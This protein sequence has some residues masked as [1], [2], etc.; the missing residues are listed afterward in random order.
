MP[1]SGGRPAN[2]RG[3]KIPAEIDETDNAT[4]LAV[5]ID[6]GEVRRLNSAPC[7]G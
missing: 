4:S 2:G 1:R 3:L 5:R 6:G 7:R